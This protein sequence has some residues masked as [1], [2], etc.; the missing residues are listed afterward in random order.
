MKTN[1]IDRALRVLAVLAL[2]LC[3]LTPAFAQAGNPPFQVWAE[4]YNAWSFQSVSANTYTF[5]GSNCWV[6]PQTSGVTASFFA[7]YLLS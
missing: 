2:V 7:L 3:G 1:W 5:P 6:S 4:Q